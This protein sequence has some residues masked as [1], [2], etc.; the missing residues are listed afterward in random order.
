MKIKQFSSL[1][2]C[3]QIFLAALA[4]RFFMYLISALILAFQAGE[5]AAFGWEYF[6]TCWCKWDAN[7]Y[8]NIAEHGYAGA[9]E[10]GKHL[11]L[12]FFP[13]Y[14]YLMSFLHLI[15]SDIR[16]VGMLISTMAYAGGCVYMYRLIRLDYSERTAWNSIILLSLFPFSFFY[17]GIMTEG[18]FL[19][20]SAAML[21]YIRQHKW[22]TAVGFGILA[23]MTRMQGVLLA[24]PAAVELLILYD[25]VQMVRKRDF[26][27]LKSLL[28]RGCSF[29]LMFL[30]TAFYMLINWRMEGDP[31]RFLYY[32]KNQ[33][34]RIAFEAFSRSSFLLQL[35]SRKS[36]FPHHCLLSSK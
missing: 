35:L 21:Y 36:F 8:I 20:I 4:F 17:G 33:N 23:T 15:F 25:P 5:G 29:F 12:V 30:G 32:Q 3:L 26:S 6:L 11:F 28:G 34:C 22:W 27:K 7:H 31:F 24:V 10:D 16:F 14:P 9:V 18:V 19:L 2:I 13:L 1:N